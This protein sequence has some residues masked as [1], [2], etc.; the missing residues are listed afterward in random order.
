MI[1]IEEIPFSK[2]E[3]L[4]PTW[5]IKVAYEYKTSIFRISAFE[6]VAI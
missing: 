1:G 5:K 4:A 2:I 6:Y 3:N